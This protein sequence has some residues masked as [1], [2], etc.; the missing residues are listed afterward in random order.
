[1]KL[2]K[3]A[4]ISLI[5]APLATS[6]ATMSNHELPQ[7][8]SGTVNASKKVALSYKMTSG[9]EMVKGARQEFQ[10]EVNKQLAST[11]E[12]TARGSGRFSSVNQGGSGAVRLEL[13]LLNH[14]DGTSAAISG[15]ISGFSLMTIPGF[16]TDRYR[17]TAKVQGSSGKS[18]QYVL[19]DSVTTVFWL[20]LIVATPFSSPVT[21][22]PKTQENLYRNLFQKMEA[23]GLL[24]KSAAGN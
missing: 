5:I 6:C 10:P 11:F 20:P 9:H 22:V 23:D 3:L 1:M 19:D 13:D 18:R 12:T 21:V 8:G 7:I 15:F 4:S 2:P 24:P 16:A 14:G 17:L